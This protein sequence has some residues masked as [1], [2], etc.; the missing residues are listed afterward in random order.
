VTVDGRRV[1]GWTYDR[2]TRTVRLV[3]DRVSSRAG[4]TVRLR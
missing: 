1:T 2:G 4:A 3:L